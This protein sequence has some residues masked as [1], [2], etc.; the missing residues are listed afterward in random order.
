MKKSKF[1]EEHIVYDRR[2]VDGGHPG[3][4]GIF[5]DQHVGEPKC[6]ISL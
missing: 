1:T 3:P 6:V 5:A 2:Q 4:E